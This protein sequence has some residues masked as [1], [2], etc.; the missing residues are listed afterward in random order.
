MMES[1]PVG[2][3]KFPIYGKLKNVPHHH[4]VSHLNPD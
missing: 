1:G 2:M 3:M 4:P